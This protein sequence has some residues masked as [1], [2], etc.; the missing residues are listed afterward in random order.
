MIRSF[1][2]V[3]TD[4][5][6]LAALSEATS[7]VGIAESCPNWGPEIKEYLAKVGIDSPKPYC[8]AAVSDWMVRG[9]YASQIAPPINPTAL[10][11]GLA[12]QF[13]AAGRWI[14]G[15][16]ARDVIRPGM[17]VVWDRATPEE[18]WRGHT[19]IVEYAADDGFHTVE[20]NIIT[21]PGAQGV[22]RLVRPYDDERLMGFGVLSGPMPGETIA[23][24]LVLLPALASGRPV[25]PGSIG[26]LVAGFALGLGAIT[27]GVRL[28]R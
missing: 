28:A 13:E 10:A 6:G 7:D 15:A 21:G 1:D 24:A 22:G 23:P 9:S 25:H 14:P 26:P 5:L 12:E 3:S 27:L 4:E 20:A 2:Q 16:G 11:K 17:V 19:G 18:P 8:A